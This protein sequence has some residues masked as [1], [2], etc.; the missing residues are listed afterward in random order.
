MTKDVKF[1]FT[2][3]FAA[4]N[5]AI[6]GDDYVTLAPA[7]LP[8]A[9]NR[10]SL[11]Y[12]KDLYVL[13]PEVVEEVNYFYK[14]LSLVDGNEANIIQATAGV[15]ASLFEKKKCNFN[16]MVTD[17][18][19]AKKIYSL[20]LPLKFKFSIE[21]IHGDSYFTIPAEFAVDRFKKSGLSFWVT[22][23]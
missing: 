17:L 12:S 3:G 22:S 2:V 7:G 23:V 14:N 9:G 19:L 16:C 15:I 21:S 8:L 18:A 5:N 10:K 11:N 6:I 20:L 13:P 1:Y 4:F